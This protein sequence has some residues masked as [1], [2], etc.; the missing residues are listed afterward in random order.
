MCV[1][2]DYRGVNRVK[3]L[4]LGIAFTIAGAGCLSFPE[5]APFFMVL[6]LV[7]ICIG[8]LFAISGAAKKEPKD[9]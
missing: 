4:L 9:Q 8:L 5:I 1:S 7:F 3:R 6:G 2:G